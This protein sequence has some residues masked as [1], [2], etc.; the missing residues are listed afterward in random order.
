LKLSVSNLLWGATPLEIIAKELSII[1]LD[2]IEIAPKVI[3]P[4]LSSI[5]AIDVNKVRLLLDDHGLQVSGVQSL[6]FGH[7][8][9]Q[10]F[11]KSTWSLMLKH[12]EM[13]IE[14][15]TMLGAKV[16]VF[17]S[18]KNRIKGTLKEENAHEIAADFLSRIIPS[19]ERNNVV[20]TLEPNAPAYGADYLVDYASVVSLAQIIGSPQI[21]P[22]IDTGCMWMVGEDLVSSF[23]NFT[24]HHIHLSTPHLKEVP[25]AHDFGDFLQ[26]IEYEE[27]CGWVVIESLG[28]S[29]EDAIFSADWL[30]RR[31]RRS[32]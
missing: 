14:I 7:P 21:A 10:M 5:S 30:F 23:K 22:Q 32:I 20:L 8:E 11:N 4:D 13:M 29:T 17:G 19:L 6:F 3:W 2:G 15:T 28:S 18:P 1:G 9:F 12:L 16:A 27:Y 24:P 26:I 31:M 25:G